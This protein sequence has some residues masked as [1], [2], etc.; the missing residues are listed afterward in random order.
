MSDLMTVIS[1]GFYL[2][3][4]RFD[5]FSLFY[6][7]CVYNINFSLVQSLSADQLLNSTLWVKSSYFDE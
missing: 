1:A 6:H 5:S 2:D 4:L 7:V 3:V